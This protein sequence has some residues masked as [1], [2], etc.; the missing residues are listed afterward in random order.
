[1]L[2]QRQSVA[3]SGGGYVGGWKRAL[4]RT[5][6]LVHAVDVG[7]ILFLVFFVLEQVEFG[8]E[9]DNAQHEVTG[10]FKEFMY[11]CWHVE[12][13]RRMELAGQGRSKTEFAAPV[14]GGPLQTC[15]SLSRFP[16]IECLCLAMLIV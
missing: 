1:M 5:F 11:F 8:G 13:S 3:W 12:P 14:R 2:L 6:K 15:C 4:F 7:V 16:F 10:C 9:L